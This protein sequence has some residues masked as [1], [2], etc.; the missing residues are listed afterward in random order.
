MLISSVFRATVATGVDHRSPRAGDTAKDAGLNF[1][2]RRG[3]SRKISDEAGESRELCP[4]AQER[5]Q[6]AAE[7]I[8]AEMTKIARDPK[9]PAAARVSAYREISDVLGFHAPPKGR[10]QE[11][12]GLLI[13]HDM[14]D[15]DGVAL[16][17]TEGAAVAALPPVE[18]EEK[19]SGA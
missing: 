1:G 9:V 11:E 8:V 7:Q 3:V 18:P 10:A 15:P 6:I 5:S 12:V 16:A 4:E 2:G 13:I 19:P 14:P 17:V